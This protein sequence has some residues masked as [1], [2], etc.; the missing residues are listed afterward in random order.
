MSK[1][2]KLDKYAFLVASLF[3]VLSFSACGDE[4]SSNKVEEGAE[5]IGPDGKVIPDSILASDSLYTWY[6][7][8]LTKEN[9]PSD[10]SGKDS[11]KSSSSAKDGEKNSGSEGGEEKDIT[12]DD[13]EED[14]KVHF[15]PPAG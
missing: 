10:S 15:L 2:F 6:L 5:V 8:R 4:A 9:N 1:G 12:G 11:P 3:L 14:A 7:E 13:G